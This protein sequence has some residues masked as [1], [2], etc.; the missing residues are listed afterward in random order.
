M[1]KFLRPDLCSQSNQ[2]Y[3]Y[4]NKI[5]WNSKQIVTKTSIIPTFVYR[6]LI[7]NLVVFF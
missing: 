1:S 2:Y 5:R 6:V 7:K 4:A 3:H